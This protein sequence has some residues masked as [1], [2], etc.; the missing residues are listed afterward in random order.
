MKKALWMMALTM[1]L[2]AA[3]CSKSDSDEFD[4][5]REYA[6]DNFR[7]TQGNIREKLIG[8]W[9]VEDFAFVDYNKEWRYPKKEEL[10]E[11]MRTAVFRPDSTGEF[12]GLEG[13]Y[14]SVD[15]W[16]RVVIT[17]AYLWAYD[18][19]GNE[20]GGCQ[21]GSGWFGISREKAEKH[22]REKYPNLVLLKDKQFTDIIM[23]VRTMSK[24]RIELDTYS[25]YSPTYLVCTLIRK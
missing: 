16:K 23:D 19:D 2:V 8:V 5:D 18:K 3:G 9:E 21:L 6:E 15:D 14:W 11:V 13:M 20:L 10:P 1:C 12:L 25:Q 17:S 7:K 22:L 24:N 4:F